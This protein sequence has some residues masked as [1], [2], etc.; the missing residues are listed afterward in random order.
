MSEI[1]C[2]KDGYFQNLQVEGKTTFA[3]FINTDITSSNASDTDINLTAVSSDHK[4]YTTGVLSAAVRLPQATASNLGMVIEVFIGATTENGDDS[5]T[6]SVKDGDSTVFIGG[7]TTCRSLATAASRPG[8]N[9]GTESTSIGITTNARSIVLD[10]DNVATAGG[11][12]GSYYKFTY[13]AVNK[14]FVEGLGLVNLDAAT[15]PTAAGS[16]TD[17]W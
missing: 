15:A 8:G 4:L 1:G 6:L 7:Y 5:C 3:G 16:V 9:T 2:L 17:G 13:V 12:N 11:A 10:S 14:V